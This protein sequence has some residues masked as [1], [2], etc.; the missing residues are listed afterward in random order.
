MMRRIQPLTELSKAEASNKLHLLSNLLEW[1]EQLIDT[2]TTTQGAIKVF[3]EIAPTLRGEGPNEQTPGSCPA[4]G[5]SSD[6]LQ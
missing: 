5:R 4:P 2:L 3:T 6:A 1:H